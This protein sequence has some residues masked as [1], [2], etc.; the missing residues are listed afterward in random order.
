MKN[1]LLISQLVCVFFF[2]S[3]INAQIPFTSQ[4]T[5]TTTSL[6]GIS[7]ADTTMGYACGDG[8]VILKTINGGTTWTALTSGTSNNLWDIKVV[9]NTGGQKIITVGDNN[10]VRKSVNGGTSWTALSIPWASG[11]F[12]FGVQCLDS[13]N[14]FVC[15]GI[16]GTFN[17]AVLKTTNGGASWT[18]TNVPGSFFLDKVFML[19]PTYG[20]NV[21]TATATDG[22]IHKTS[23]GT[24]YTTV[25]S[26]SGIVTNLW[27]NNANNIVAVGL[28]GQIWK[29]T[30]AGTSWVSHSFNST[31]LYGI[32]FADSL[33]GF[34]CGGTPAGNIILQTIDGGN[35]WTQI[36]FSFNGGLQ[37]ICIIGN[38]IYIAGDLGKIIKATHP[39]PTGINDVENN[40]AVSVYPNPA[41]D[42]INIAVTDQ[43]SPYDF[44]LFN[45]DGK[46]V[47]HYFRSEPYSTFDVNI[48]TSGIYYY[49]FLLSN[50]KKYSGKL[51]IE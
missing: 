31:D 48:L 5:N 50:N 30:D 8:G 40:N 17:G 19:N 21:G 13:V 33:N 28:S 7:F 1:K 36:P 45:V 22:T 38:K 43:F 29:S 16:V 24:S 26:S 47:K 4:T 35:T 51:V 25:K 46:I 41:N 6:K 39:F 32:Q 42:E 37:S 49:Q 44:T 18:S 34:A 14:Y 23:T 20:F 9:P 11:S 12:V 27:C 3:G 10:T 15:G 2:T